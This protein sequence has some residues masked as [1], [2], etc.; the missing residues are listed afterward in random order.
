M[1]CT[2]RLMEGI[3]KMFRKFGIGLMGVCLSLSILL[4]TSGCLYTHIRV[5]GSMVTRGTP[6]VEKQGT[7]ECRSILWL[8]AWGDAGIQAAVKQGGLK[9][10]SYADKTYQN[11]FF[12][13]YLSEK[14]VVY[15]E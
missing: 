3:A 1:I 6:V 13:L 5:P 9:K 7:S 2:I 14:T 10:M 4:M 12:G 15:G 8:F 11:I